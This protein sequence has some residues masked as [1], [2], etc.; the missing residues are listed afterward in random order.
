MLTVLKLAGKERRKKGKAL[1]GLELC[2]PVP[3]I[4][5]LSSLPELRVD[6]LVTLA[7]IQS[8]GDTVRWLLTR[9]TDQSPGVD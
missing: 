5:S 2:S 7:D 4:I 8:S 3:R 9:L 1:G 6:H